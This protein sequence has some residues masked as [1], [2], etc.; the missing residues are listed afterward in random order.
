MKRGNEGRY[1]IPAPLFPFA[2]AL[3][4]GSV[5]AG[6]T[7]A[8][9]SVGSVQLYIL[10]LLWLHRSELTPWL[11]SVLLLTIGLGYIW[12]TGAIPP[13]LPTDLR[14]LP[15]SKFEPTAR[16]NGKVVSVPDFSL[17]AKNK[18]RSDFLLQID[19][20]W[21]D[22]KWQPATGLVQTRVTEVAENSLGYGDILEIEAPLRLPDPP[23][24]PGQLDYPHYLAQHGIYFCAQLPLESVHCLG[25]APHAGLLRW[26]SPLRAWS[27]RAL[28]LGL[29]DDSL[30]PALL[31][32]MLYGYRANI[33]TELENAFRQTGTYHIFA[34]S[35]QNMAVL[36]ALILVL[37]EPLRLVRWRWGWILIPLTMGFCWFTGAQPSSVRAL[38]S[39]VLVLLAWALGRPAAPLQIWSL[40]LISLL[41]LNPLSI[42]DIGFQLSF[43][44]VLHLILFTARFAEPL[45]KIGAVDPYLPHSLYSRAQQWQ[46][47]INRSLSQL[48]AGSFAAWLGSL[49]L[50]FVYFHQIGWIAL[51]ANLIVVPL[52]GV[53]V[54]VGAL[55][56][57]SAALSSTIAGL[58]N[59]S[60]WL[61]LK[62]ML[63]SVAF[64]AQIPHGS[65]WVAPPN[66][67]FQDC[68]P[69]LIFPQTSDSAVALL[70]YRGHAWLI[71]TG[72]DHDF[73]YVLNP[74]RKY[75]GVNELDAVILAEPNRRS[76]AG[77]I[78][79][80][81]ELP[82]HSW[83]A[84][85]DHGK[86]P[87][88]PSFLKALQVDGKG[89]AVWKAGDLY[90]WGNDLH[91]RIL[92]AALA[93]RARRLEDRGLVF[94]MDY[95]G[96]S[97]LWAGDIGFGTEKRILQ[98][99]LHLQ[100]DVLLEGHHPSDPNLSID[101]LRAIRPKHLIRP[102]RG[103][104]PDD[105]KQD[106]FAMLPVE[107]RPKIWSL[108]E[109]G[110]LTV[111]LTDSG[112]KIAPFLAPMPSLNSAD[113]EAD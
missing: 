100:S 110:A 68:D 3:T 65:L 86:G 8:P 106:A 13:V 76:C 23:A 32:G 81:H 17:N 30:T 54:V 6:F 91:I 21:S 49:P 44:V 89:L 94:K 38:V 33:P 104:Y 5:L 85:P 10:A 25:I 22:E 36:L 80:S 107:D 83:I 51:I 45:E 55:S 79:F 2:L 40:A 14:S 103:F 29:E 59:N 88:F 113:P 35:G 108:K 63:A 73:R 92:S 90:C 11:L 105:L 16:W 53:I 43:A 98:E 71:N 24:N 15:P 95:H 101:W 31:A 19:A 99:S 96:H 58:F 102:A 84:S 74:L 46:T 52:A 9:V 57:A 75:Y 48:V 7:L 12:T 66:E 67:W 77:A 18:T 60:N 109:T 42:Q 64:C 72:S 87:F 78:N 93:Y 41:I 20:W 34:V 37:F 61:L 47:S 28:S 82:V 50:M 56:L 97:I 112:I 111:A 69:V 1:T 62:I 39:A 27:N 70:R 26:I 4:F